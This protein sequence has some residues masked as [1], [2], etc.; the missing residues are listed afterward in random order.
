MQ[1]VSQVFRLM[2]YGSVFATA[3][4]TAA[5]VLTYAGVAFYPVILLFPVL[6]IIIPFL[7]WAWRRVPVK[8]AFAAMFGDLPRGMKTVLIFL[9]VYAVINLLAA[10][11]LNEHGSA[12]RDGDRLLL[13]RKS[14]I[15]RELTPEEFQLAGARD[16]RGMTG[17]LILG[18]ALAACALHATCR[19]PIPVPAPH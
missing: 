7:Y 3:A 9:A 14:E 1:P 12:V 15:L 5:H 10:T 18:F 16:V 4:C 2:F 13:K 11:S 8:Q 19:R 17:H 6:F